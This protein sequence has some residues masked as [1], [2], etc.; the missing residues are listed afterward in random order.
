MLRRFIHRA[1]KEDGVRIYM[2]ATPKFIH[3]PVVQLLTKFNQRALP[4]PQFTYVPHLKK[5]IR[6]QIKIKHLTLLKQGQW[7][8]FVPSIEQGEE[9]ESYLKKYVSNQNVTFV[10]SEDGARVEKINQFRQQELNILVTT[11]ILE[12]GVTFDDVSVAIFFPE[13]T[14]M[15]KEMIIQICGRVDRGVKEAAYQLLAYYGVFTD[16][17]HSVSKQ[18]K[19]MNDQREIL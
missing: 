7:L 14:L 3:G 18:I 2:T 6:Y 16:K 11:S 9:L 4:T 19:E 5:R 15:T 12:R 13:H 8:V 1:L 10:Y 17:I